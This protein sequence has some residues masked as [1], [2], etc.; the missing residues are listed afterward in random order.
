M[1]FF[2]KKAPVMHKEKNAK[3]EMFLVTNCSKKEPVLHN[4]AHFQPAMK[5]MGVSGAQH[6][7]GFGLLQRL[8]HMLIFICSGPDSRKPLSMYLRAFLNTDVI[9]N[10]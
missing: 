10:Y 9:L 8:M 7:S 4:M 3:M 1:V 5:S 6:H 2:V